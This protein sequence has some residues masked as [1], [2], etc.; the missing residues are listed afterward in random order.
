MKAIESIKNRLLDI[1]LPTAPA[2]AID[3]TSIALIVISALI[4]LLVPVLIFRSQGFK[5]KRMLSHLKEE[6]SSSVITPREASYQLANIIKTAHKT[7]QLKTSQDTPLAWNDF[8][9]RLSE[10]RYQSVKNTNKEILNLIDDARHWLK[11]PQP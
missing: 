6:L 9:C 8:V 5:Q 4:I 2:E 10:S 1:E 3:Y 7:S 11:A